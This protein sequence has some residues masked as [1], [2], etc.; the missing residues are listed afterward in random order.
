MCA[1]WQQS[2]QAMRAG[3]ASKN[4][5]SNRTAVGLAFTWI[6][7]TADAYQISLHPP[8]DRRCRGPEATS[9]RLA[10]DLDSDFFRNLAADLFGQAIVNALGA[11]QRGAFGD[12]RRGGGD[13][14][15]DA[16]RHR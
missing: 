10:G 16:Q 4:I 7:A 12:N 2:W 1:G 13:G 9:L 14:H 3:A 6:I 15:H 11:L 8:S 5:A